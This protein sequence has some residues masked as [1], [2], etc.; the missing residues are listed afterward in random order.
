[1]GRVG[2]GSNYSEA[3]GAFCIWVTDLANGTVT[4][5]DTL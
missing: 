4:G 3:V 2:M 1:M 5:N